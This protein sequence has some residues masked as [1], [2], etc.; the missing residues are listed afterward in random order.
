MTQ[1]GAPDTSTA[2]VLAVIPAKAGIHAASTEGECGRR[3]NAPARA[4]AVET[5]AINPI[6]MP[7]DAFGRGSYQAGSSWEFRSG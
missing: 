1:G 2:G 4:G 6:T 3:C 7:S 5:T